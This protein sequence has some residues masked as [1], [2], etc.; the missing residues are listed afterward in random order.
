MDE[1]GQPQD[2]VARRVV[3][4]VDEEQQP[5]LVRRPLGEL[6]S[7]AADEGRVVAVH[8]RIDHREFGA[9]VGRQVRGAFEMAREVRRRHGDVDRG[10]AELGRPAGAI[11]DARD[12]RSLA[13]GHDEQPVL[14]RP[15]DRVGR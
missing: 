8:G 1:L 4:A 15:C 3:V 11:E 2:R 12:L 6:A 14:P 5:A 13:G 9:R 7:I 10:E